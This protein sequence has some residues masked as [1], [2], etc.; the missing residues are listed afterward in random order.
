MNMRHVLL[1]Y[2]FTKNFII[3]IDLYIDLYMAVEQKVIYIITQ[4]VIIQYIECI[5]IYVHY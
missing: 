5:A 3:I 2:G 4:Y 1:F